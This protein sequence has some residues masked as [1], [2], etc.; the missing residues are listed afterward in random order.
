MNDLLKFKDTEIGKNIVLFAPGPTLNEFSFDK[1][2]ELKTYKKAGVNGVILHDNIIEDL[3]YYIFSGD[4]DIPEHPVPLYK[5]VIERLSKLN[6]T[7]KKFTNPWTDDNLI[8]N[9]HT[10]SY[11]ISPE[12]ADK[13]GFYKYNQTYK[14]N[15]PTD[16]FYKELGVYGSGVDG[17]SVAFHAVQILLYMGFKNIVLVGFDCGGDHSYK[18]L[19]EGDVCDWGKGIHKRLVNRW[20]MFKNFFLKKYTDRKISSIN[21]IGL[22]KI[23]PEY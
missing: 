5:H 10:K 12:E 20:K 11:Q 6:S 13:L 9:N 17:F 4:I 18:N 22:K 7:T 2:P 21:P 14:N 23:F 15:H 16:Y 1:F 8:Y 3:D 19:V